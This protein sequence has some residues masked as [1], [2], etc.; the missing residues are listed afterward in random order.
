MKYPLFIFLST[1]SSVLATSS[2][3]FNEW[4]AD[5]ENALLPDFS[6]AGY[7]FGNTSLPDLDSASL[8]VFHVDDYGAVPNDTVSDQPAIQRAIDEA[9]IAGGGIVRLG[10]GIYRINDGDDQWSL[11]VRHSNII[12]QG[13]GPDQTTIFSPGDM[14]RSV[15]PWTALPMLLVA[16][17]ELKGLELTYGYGEGQ[18]PMTHDWYATDTSN[19][20]EDEEDAGGYYHV[21][22][23][24]IISKVTADAARNTKS[25][26][27]AD[28]SGIQP[29]DRVTL[30]L[31]D[32]G[33]AEDLFGP[34]DSSRFDYLSWEGIE[35]FGTSTNLV[36]QILTVDS[37][38]DQTVTFKERLRWDFH[39]KYRPI[40]LRYPHIENIGIEHLTFKGLARDGVP[41]T[42]VGLVLT[43]AANSWVRNVHFMNLKT[44]VNL[45]QTKNVTALDCVLDGDG[46]ETGNYFEGFHNSMKFLGH[47]SDSL[48]EGARILRGVTHGFSCQ[49]H[50]NGNVFLDCELP[51]IGTDDMNSR[52][53][54]HSQMPYSNLYDGLRNGRFNGSGGNIG[55]QPHGGPFNVFW[56]WDSEISGQQTVWAGYGQYQL[57]VARPIWVGLEGDGPLSVQFASSSDT[58]NNEVITESIG[59]AVEPASL[60]RAQVKTRLGA[61][62]GPGIYPF[63]S[64]PSVVFAGQANSWESAGTSG[65]S[66]D[67]YWNRSLTPEGERF[68]STPSGPGLLSLELALRQDDSEAMSARKSV[69]VIDPSGTLV[70]G[71]ADAFLP[72]SRNVLRTKGGHMLQVMHTG[73]RFALNLRGSHAYFRS[74]RHSSEFNTSGSLLVAALPE[75]G[76]DL[77]EYE[78]EFDLADVATRPKTDALRLVARDTSGNWAMSTQNLNWGISTG[79]FENYG[80]M[81]LEPA[82]ELTSGAFDSS[83]VN[84]VGFVFFLDNVNWALE[85][86]KLRFDSI[87]IGRKGFAPPQLGFNGPE[88]VVAEDADS[89]TLSVYRSGSNQG[90]VSVRYSSYSGDAETSEDFSAFTG[91]L[92]WSDGESGARTIDLPLIDD[93]IYEGEERFNVVLSDFTGEAL[94]GTHTALVVRIADDE[95]D[96]VPSV[97]LESP[98]GSFASLANPGDQLVLDT[99]VRSDRPYT[100]DWSLLSGP[101]TAI[102]ENR[103]EE[104][105]TVRFDQPGSH[106]IQVSVDNGFAESTAQLVVD[107]SPQVVAAGV[108]ARWPLS[109][110]FAPTNVSPD[111]DQASHLSWHGL[112]S[113]GW[114]GIG[115]KFEGLSGYPNKEEYV[116]VSMTARAGHTID[117]NGGSVRFDSDYINGS[118]SGDGYTVEVISNPGGS[119]SVLTLGTSEDAELEFDSGPISGFVPASVVE[120]RIYWNNGQSWGDNAMGNLLISAIDSLN[121]GPVTE[122]GPDGSADAGV[123]IA[124][125][126]NVVDDGRPAPPG[127][128]TYEWTQRSG[129]GEASFTDLANPET[130]VVFSAPGTYVLRL[131]G[132]D[133]AIR[134]ADDVVYTITGL[135]LAP[136]EAWRF[137]HFNQTENSGNA[138]DDADPDGDSL[139]NIWERAWG[140]DPNDSSSHYKLVSKI[141]R[142]GESDY[143]AITYRQITGGSGKIG[144]DYTEEGITYTVHTATFLTGPWSSGA[145]EVELV[146]EPVENGDGTETVTVRSVDSIPSTPKQFLKLV[147]TAP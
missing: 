138:A 134:T 30:I 82:F 59:A 100:V 5:P 97:S 147:L 81:P 15:G 41:R 46:G 27:L 139:K 12:V 54:L 114:G 9:A 44:A 141:E 57:Q 120:L 95:L 49:R 67:A 60:Y 92:H 36:R 32:G 125:A 70:Y 28:A 115:W 84:R 2:Q 69:R 14:G 129:P 65:P 31:R 64:G 136:P 117:L 73:Q 63:V 3:L 83:Q 111:L 142:I 89:A 143:L 53:D 88:I 121:I 94:P 18:P 24:D 61:D 76:V 118:R 25:V 135:E 96:P 6:R 137:L 56:N 33:V 50:A 7:N 85:E 77:A 19:I 99:E 101:G 145:Q 78:F 68:D 66:V 113:M 140:S 104:D 103:S 52:V 40:L 29:G 105:T 17:P 123:A 8:P 130:D 10:A 126:G 124:L 20:I 23:H 16:A 110:S 133:G 132:N 39:L 144:V 91:E 58:R 26:T 93:Q 90:A 108:V 35:R 79:N 127:M 37:V 131:I 128:L 119:A 75:Q 112:K 62:P 13:A 87:W 80:W 102:F 116:S 109:S 86:D 1:V 42:K 146:S 45:S 71:K 107:V 98:L 4:V 11:M 38:V 34:W 122:A 21:R 55:T 47:S 72:V 22:N 43:N 106:V 48:I 51:P 74:T